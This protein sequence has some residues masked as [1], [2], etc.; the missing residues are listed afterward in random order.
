VPRSPRNQQE[1]L[2]AC[3]GSKTKP[4]ADFEFSGVVTE[5]LLL[6]NVALRTGRK[7]VWDAANL[8]AVN[9]A[10][11]GQYIRPPRRAGWSL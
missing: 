2:G 1:W 4:A 8:K 5:A 9:V 6:G 7:V 3:L 11:A 10:S